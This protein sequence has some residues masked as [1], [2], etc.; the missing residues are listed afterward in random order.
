VWTY[1]TECTKGELGLGSN[2][3]DKTIGIHETD[4]DGSFIDGFPPEN[5]KIVDLAASM[6]HTVAVLSNGDVYGWGNGRKGQLG[7]P[8]SIIWSPRRIEGIPFKAV[9][10][11]CGREFTYIVSHHEEG[12]HL[13]LGTDKWSVVSH[14]PQHVRWWKDIGAGWSSI[15]VLLQSGKVLSWG[16]NDHGQLSLPN[17]SNIEQL[18]VGS[19]HVL[20]LST[21]GKVLA[22]GWGEHGNCG[23]PT[24]SNGDVKDRW[25]VL[26]V[27]GK[28]LMIGAGCAT[29]FIQAADG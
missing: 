21:S 4:K 18:A 26:I 11:V 3:D 7:E 17:L 19:E 16:R 23:L 6:G 1:G 9:R 15:Y 12:S 22:W 14:A 28:V 20:T 29:S 24:E 25:N 27:P 8:R 10:A 5:T 2:T 13:V